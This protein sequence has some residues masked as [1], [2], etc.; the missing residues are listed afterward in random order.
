MLCCIPAKLKQLNVTVFF[1]LVS[2]WFNFIEKAYWLSTLQPT[3]ARNFSIN[4]INVKIFWKFFHNFVA[5]SEYW[6]FNSYQDTNG[7]GLFEYW[8]KME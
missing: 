1:C 3:P 8:T 2:F 6:D 5:L 4:V 7:L